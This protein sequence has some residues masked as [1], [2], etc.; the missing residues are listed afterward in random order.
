MN[1]PLASMYASQ[2]RGAVG[3]DVIGPSIGVPSGFDGQ[4][5]A[6]KDAQ[7]K[8]SNACWIWALDGLVLNVA[9]Y[10]TVEL[11]AG[12]LRPGGS[13]FS[14]SGAW[15]RAAVSPPWISSASAAASTRTGVEPQ[16]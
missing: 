13:K 1:T 10:G 7:E 5:S 15:A 14:Q 12:K 6:T 9:S 8:M 3:L 16:D 2:T 11:T 4:L